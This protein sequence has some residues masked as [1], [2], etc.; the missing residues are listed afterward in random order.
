MLHWSDAAIVCSRRTRG[1]DAFDPGGHFNPP[2]SGVGED[3]I[4][5][6][7]RDRPRGQEQ[8][9]DDGGHH[10]ARVSRDIRPNIT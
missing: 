4:A 2:T 7:S 3:A 5:G 10:R 8:S 6:S 1:E 9:N